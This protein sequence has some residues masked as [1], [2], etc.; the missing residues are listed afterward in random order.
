MCGG[1]EKSK[2]LVSTVTLHWEHASSSFDHS[3][4][5]LLTGLIAYPCLSRLR[6][7]RYPSKYLSLMHVLRA[8]FLIFL[9]STLS[10][11][12]A[13][14]ESPPTALGKA[15][16]TTSNRLDPRT[17]RF[18]SDCDAQTFCSGNVNGTCI[19]R[20]CRREEC[21]SGY[22]T[23]QTIPVLC[24]A[25]SFCPDEGDACRPLVP[26][27]QP[28]QFN[29]DDECAPPNTPELADYHNFDGSVCLHSIC[30]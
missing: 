5:P 7:R 29:R 1:A 27:G 24:P 20:Q 10:V 22:G 8:V 28:C 3:A 23:N 14:S 18:T 15:C 26:V 17:R 13:A 16:L 4:I 12:V 11:L 6:A 30:T 9:Q 25:G 19:S 2:F 21:P